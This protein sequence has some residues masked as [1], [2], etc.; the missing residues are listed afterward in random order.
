MVETTISTLSEIERWF[1]EN[2]NGDWEHSYG[3]SIET[4]DNPG[5]SVT[6]QVTDTIL[7]GLE[8]TESHHGPRTMREF[9]PAN[10]YD[11]YYDWYEIWTEPGS[12]RA[13][14]APRR[15]TFVL[16]RFLEVALQA[17]QQFGGYGDPDEA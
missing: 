10:A 16:N 1:H 12:F 5:W 9:L 8:M 6:I 3:V 11:A 14:C 2:C 4:M 15:L 17:E 13:F 7:E